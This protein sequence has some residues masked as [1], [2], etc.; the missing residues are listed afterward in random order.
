MDKGPKSSQG[1]MLVL[2]GGGGKR[3]AFL[4][5]CSAFRQIGKGKELFLYILNCLFPK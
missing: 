5:L 1:L 3:D 4:N 2:S